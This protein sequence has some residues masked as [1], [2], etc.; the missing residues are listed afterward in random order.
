MTD[1]GYGLTPGFQ[2]RPRDC[3]GCANESPLLGGVCLRRT[4]VRRRLRGGGAAARAAGPYPREPAV[5]RV[6]LVDDQALVRAGFAMIARR[7]GRHRGGR[8]GRRRRRG[9]AQLGRVCRPDVVL[10]DIRMPATGRRRG[11]PAA[12]GRAARRPGSSCSPP[13]T[14]TSTPSRRCAPAPAAS[15]SRTHRPTTARGDPHRRR[16]AMPLIAPSATRRLIDRVAPDLPTPAA[17]DPALD[18]LTDRE[19]RGAAADRRGA[20]NAE[21]AGRLYSPRP[22]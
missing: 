17:R 3:W 5:I 13:S 15:C 8:R 9:G 7:R 4:A 16:A 20:S 6:F 22:R 1:D 11:D 10:M 14:S 18:Q 12:R 2:R 21:I 19:R